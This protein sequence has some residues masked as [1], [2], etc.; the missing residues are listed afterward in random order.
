MEVRMQGQ[1]VDRCELRRAGGFSGDVGKGTPREESTIGSVGIERRSLR[2]WRA[3]KSRISGKSAALFVVLALAPP[4]ASANPTLMVLPT[5][6]GSTTG[7]DLIV[8]PAGRLFGT[9]GHGFSGSLPPT[10]CDA[11][12][13]VQGCGIVFEVSPD[14]TSLDILHSFSGSDGKSPT[15]GLVADSAG[16]LFGAARE[17]GGSNCTDA[18]TVVGCGTIYKIASNKT[19]KVLYSFSGASDGQSPFGLITD[20]AGNLYGTTER[21]GAFGLGTV[22]KLAKKGG[23]TVLHSFGDRPDDGIRPIG[24][25]VMDATGTLFGATESG[26][27]TNCQLE[28]P[29]GGTVFKLAPDG[30]SYEVLHKFSPTAGFYPNSLVF[31]RGN[32]FGTTLYGGAPCGE[33]PG[34]GV[35]FKLTTSGDYTVL[36]AFA[37]GSDGAEPNGNLIFDSSGNLYGTTQTFFSGIVYK[38]GPDGSGYTV[39][40]EFDFTEGTSLSGLIL[41]GAGVLFGTASAGGVNLGFLEE[42]CGGTGFRCG[43]IYKLAP[44]GTF[45]VLY[46]FQFETGGPSNLVA[47]PAGNLYGTLA[48][49]GAVF[50]LAGTGFVTKKSAALK[51]T[52]SSDI[53]AA[54]AKRGTVFSASAF[55]Y[56][57]DATTGKIDVTVS[58]LPTWLS[59]SFASAKLTA[60]S[61]LTDTFSLANLRKL[62]RGTYNATIQ[63]TNTTNDKGSTTR[64]ASLRI[65]DWR[66]CKHGGWADFPSPPGPF[67][68]KLQCIVY[69]FPRLQASSGLGD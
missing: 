41:D 16:N 57:L 35:V 5:D 61:P 67:G 28:P 7:S 65:Y 15:G 11:P 31:D 51:V 52:P 32:L 44:S 29:C 42:E 45:T 25:M 9:G 18:G 23:F 63:F 48:I 40:H 47:D 68:N 2:W 54:A 59:A 49:G 46:D 20:H 50:K 19:S 53:V 60:G 43:T 33:I 21:G 24:S 37:S 56:K 10:N 66:D 22:F 64:S 58:G 30:S 27:D 12:A 8:D 4:S 62:A 26:G 39:L 17:G 34:C 13:L 55:D 69:F 1:I 36:H 3:T 14:G 6:D 38:I